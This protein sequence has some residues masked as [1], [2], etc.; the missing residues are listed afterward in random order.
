M[1]KGHPRGHTAR[2]GPESILW[3]LR[4]ETKGAPLGETQKEWGVVAARGEAPSPH[5]SRAEKVCYSI[6]GRGWE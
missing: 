3:K 6:W 2:H 4:V 5:Q 1:G